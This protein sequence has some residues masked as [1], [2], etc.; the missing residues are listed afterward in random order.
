MLPSKIYLKKKN[1][2]FTKLLPPKNRNL[3]R[4]ETRCRSYT[5]P[6]FIFLKYELSLPTWHQIWCRKEQISLSI[7]WPQ[8]QTAIFL[9]CFTFLP[10]IRFLFRTISYFPISFEALHNAQQEHGCPPSLKLLV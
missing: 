4:E 5:F 8:N 2:W 9:I 7:L 10:D 3:K 1:A 6:H